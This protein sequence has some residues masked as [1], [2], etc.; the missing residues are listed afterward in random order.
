[1]GTKLTEISTKMH[2][3]DIQIHIIFVIFDQSTLKFGE[4]IF[5]GWKETEM[6]FWPFTVPAKGSNKNCGRIKSEGSIWSSWHTTSRDLGIGNYPL[7]FHIFKNY[8]AYILTPTYNR[9]NV[10]IY[11][12]FVHLSL[13][14][15]L[16][17]FFRGPQ[18]VFQRWKIKLL[19]RV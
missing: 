1:M 8:A 16:L 12:L 2:N 11:V 6:K 17:P 18:L 14:S 15:P 10:G 7:L 5:S 9:T 13:F 19:S 3:M 4:K